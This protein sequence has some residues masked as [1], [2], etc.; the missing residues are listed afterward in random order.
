[1]IPQ[2]TIITQDTFLISLP[3]GYIPHRDIS[4]LAQD[5]VEYLYLKAALIELIS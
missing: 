5:L 4:N 1:M 2:M 3:A